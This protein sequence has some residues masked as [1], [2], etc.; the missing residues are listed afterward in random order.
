MLIGTDGLRPDQFDPEIMPTYASLMT[1]GCELTNH[2]SVYPSSTRCILPALGTGCTP[3]KHG[4][5]SMTLRVDDVTPSHIVKTADA[6]DIAALDAATGG[7]AIMRP[8]LG[9][10]LERH[11]KRLGVAGAQTSGGGAI[12]ARHQ[13]FPKLVAATTYDRPENQA[14]WERMGEPPPAM[15]EPTR[16]PHDLYIARG[17][18]DVL[19]DDDSLDLIIVW[20]A[21]PDYVLHKFGP[22]SPEARQAMVDCDQSLA[23]IL[24]GLDRRGLRDQFDILLI[25]D[26]GHSS[27]NQQGTFAEQLDRARAELGYAMPDVSIADNSL[28]HVPGA[29]VP[30]ANALAPLVEWLQEQAWVG[31]VL[32][33]TPEIAS[34]PGVIPLAAVWNGSTN[35]RAPLLSI[36][37]SWSDD[38]NQFGVPGMVNALVKHGGNVSTHGSASPYEMHAMAWAIGESFKAGSATSLPSGAT[39]IAP[40]ILTLL[41]IELPPDIDG[42]V[43]RE[44]MRNPAGE[45]DATR[46]SIV[47]PQ[48][49]HRRFQPVLHLHHV[50]NTS[51]VH[52]IDNG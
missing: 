44:A 18:A 11:G 13:H 9:D 4:F 12:W 34:L 48:N 27:V 21:E 2:H 49:A 22:G 42:R 31:A 32:G 6:N 24:E 16:N 33:G 7:N 36:S 35:E 39:D 29:P 17:V 28:Y 1:Q 40:T 3:G 45:P 8:T 50:G 30:E 52:R 20:L 47:T 5:V 37:P 14:I 46:T 41:G 10:V 23:I 51:Y 25:S 26:H 19:L 38:R 43:L 15:S